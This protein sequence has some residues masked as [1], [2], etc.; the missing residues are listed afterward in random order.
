MPKQLIP[1]NR[2][3]EGKLPKTRSYC[4]FFIERRKETKFAASVALMNEFLN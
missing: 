3:P 1:V 2:V 4:L